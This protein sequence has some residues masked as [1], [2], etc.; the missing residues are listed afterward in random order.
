MNSDDAIDLLE[1]EDV[2]LLALFA[3]F[4]ETSGQGVVNQSRHGDLGKQLVRRMAVREAAKMD[5]V[6]VIKHAGE[7]GSLGAK[8][9]GDDPK[10]RRSGINEIDRMTRHVR[11]IDIDRAQDFDG[12][13]SRLRAIVAPEI[14]WELSEGMDALRVELAPS[15]RA[16]LHRSHYLRRRAPTKLHRDGSRWYERSWLVGWLVTKWNHAEDRPRPIPGAQAD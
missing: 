9:T 8:L 15:Q 6:R 10:G 7:M 12:A 16:S 4:D 11:A 3:Q 13:V 1:E 14:E 5:I 2:A